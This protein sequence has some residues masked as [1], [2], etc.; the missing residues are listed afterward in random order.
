MAQEWLPRLLMC[1]AI[2]LTIAGCRPPTLIQDWQAGRDLKTTARAGD[3]DSQYRLGMRYT[4]GRGVLQN[5]TEAVTW[6]SQAAG[7]GH[8]DAQFMLG[9]A[10]ASGRGTELD[11]EQALRWFGKAADA[12]HMRAQ[13]QLGD[14]Y[15]N[16]QGV[17]KD[18]AWG[19]RW[20]GMAASQGHSEAQFML[21]AL[22]SAGLGLPKD[23]TR[24]IFWLQLASRGGH[25]QAGKALTRM[26]QKVS[27]AQYRLAS[28]KAEQWQP[29]Q[30]VRGLNNPPTI[31]YIQH[32]LNQLGYAVGAVD[33][34]RGPETERTIMRFQTDQGLGPNPSLQ[35]SVDLL[36]DRSPDLNP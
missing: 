18:L 6:F 12:G 14:A 26:R 3:A 31:S 7:Q 27:T 29:A 8:A 9:A 22:Y 15:S 28:A 16:G 30:R 36:R 35:R 13:Y 1:L 19:A 32:V 11:R 33:G 34:I 5:H 10:F 21:A 23:Y 25:P 20:Y 4:N 17:R 24:A 2:P